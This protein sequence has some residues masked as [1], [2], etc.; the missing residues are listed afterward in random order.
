M[1]KKFPVQPYNPAEWLSKGTCEVT[2]V[3]GPME[4]T[5]TLCVQPEKA[6]K[7]QYVYAVSV[8]SFYK[9]GEE[10]TS[11]CDAFSTPEKAAD[12][13]EADWNWQAD[14]YNGK[15]LAKKAK[16]AF[17]AALKDE[18]KDFIAEAES[19]AEWGDCWFKWNGVRTEI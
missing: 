18:K 9:N 1:S 10:L 7:K 17:I 3:E 5:E 16:K 12:W 19:P 14:C 8:A 6:E 15:K 13:F 4:G 11:H 2:R